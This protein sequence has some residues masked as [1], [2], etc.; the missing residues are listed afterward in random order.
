MASI[1]QVDQKQ[2]EVRR[3]ALVVLRQLAK[4]D[5]AKYIAPYLDLIVPQVQ[6]CVKDRIIFVKLAAEKALISV[7]QLSEG[8]STLQRYLA[9]LDSAN[10]QTVGD[11]AKR[12]LS[13]IEDEEEEEEAEEEL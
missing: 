9:T 7:F 8:Q 2:N 6:A 12:V 10:A 3:E 5:H 11:Y 13:K 1:L 4:C